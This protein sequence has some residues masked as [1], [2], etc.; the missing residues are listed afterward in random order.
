MET[1]IEIAKDER[2]ESKD[3]FRYGPPNRICYEVQQEEI[4]PWS[5]YQSESG[6]EFLGKLD[7]TQQKMVL[8]IHRS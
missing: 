1:L 6:A 3:A 7:A 8:R 4:S 5:V 2:L